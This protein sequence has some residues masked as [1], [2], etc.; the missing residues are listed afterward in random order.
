MLILNAC[1]F[2]EEIIK[3]NGYQEKIKLESKKFSELMQLPAFSN[4]YKRVINKKVTLSNDIAARTALEDQYGFTIV[5]DKDVKVIID[6]DGSI[7]Y[8]MLIERAVKENLKFENLV[9]KVKNE[10]VEAIILK[11]ELNEKATY[12][13]EYNYINV[14]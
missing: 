11:Y 1:T 13:Q 2:E 12:F 4:A 7:S 14:A 3:Q 8:S 5:E 6:L 9:I 10:E